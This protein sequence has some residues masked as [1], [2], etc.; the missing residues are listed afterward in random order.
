M[1]VFLEEENKLFFDRS[2][3]QEYAQ[4][5]PDIFVRIPVKN[6]VNS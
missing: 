4:Q 6:L 3:M 1:N 5:S 2:E